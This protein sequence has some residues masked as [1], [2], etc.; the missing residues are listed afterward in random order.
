MK[1]LRL[2]Q[3]SVIVM[4]GKVHQMGLY[5]KIVANANLIIVPMEHALQE[6][7]RD[8]LETTATIKTIAIVAHASVVRALMLRGGGPV[9]AYWIIILSPLHPEEP[10]YLDLKKFR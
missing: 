6:M 2:I 8:W 5:A 7:D 4:S 9:F 3:N 10:A 1:I